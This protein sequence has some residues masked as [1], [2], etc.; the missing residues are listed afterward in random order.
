MP[1]PVTNFDK[2]RFGAICFVLPFVLLA[3][4]GLL[5]FARF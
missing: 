3:A 2:E 1:D 4:L 5:I